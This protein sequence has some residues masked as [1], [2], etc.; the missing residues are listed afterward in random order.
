VP[1]D[2]DAL[3]A[4]L[5]QGSREAAPALLVRLVVGV[6]VEHIVF[7]TPEARGESANGG[8]AN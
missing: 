4:R 7:E 2:P 6:T 5:S 8:A 1:F 3:V